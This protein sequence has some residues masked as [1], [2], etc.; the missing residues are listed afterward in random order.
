MT[1]LTIPSRELFTILQFVK[2]LLAVSFVG[3]ATGH[4]WALVTD[5]ESLN[6]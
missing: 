1:F 5:P 6:Q 3:F 4:L 2:H